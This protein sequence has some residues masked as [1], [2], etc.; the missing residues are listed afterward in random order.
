MFVK[1][2]KPLLKIMQQAI[3]QV[4]VMFIHRKISNAVR[5]GVMP[6]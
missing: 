2:L 5:K 1:K 3:I 6:K 4:I